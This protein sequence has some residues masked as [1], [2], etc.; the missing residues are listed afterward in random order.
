MLTNDFGQ[1]GVFHN[2]GSS[3]LRVSGLALFAVLFL[4]VASHAYAPC[5]NHLRACFA[6][7]ANTSLFASILYA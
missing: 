3:T 1:H 5:F 4:A 6:E 2:A 7:H